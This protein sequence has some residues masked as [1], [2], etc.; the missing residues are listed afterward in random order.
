MSDKLES[1]M[2]APLALIEEL[3]PS[4]HLDASSFDLDVCNRLLSTHNGSGW[5]ILNPIRARQAK[6]KRVL[7]VEVEDSNTDKVISICPSMITSGMLITQHGYIGRV[8]KVDRYENISR[9][10]VDE[11][12]P[13]IYSVRM[14][15]VS[16][17]L[18]MHKWFM[19]RINNGC[20]MG[21]LSSQQGNRRVTF[22]RVLEQ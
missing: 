18:A 12:E 15:Y 4:K 19:D 21:Y 2:K 5:E 10:V 6:L 22:N 9:G 1:K 14:E 8:V 13:Y 20:D 7:L 17:D 11:N 3:K 16:G